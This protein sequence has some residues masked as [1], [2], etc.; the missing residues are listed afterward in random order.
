MSIFFI[1][2]IACMTRCDFSRSGSVSSSG[3][4]VRDDLPRQAEPVL[5]PA[6]RALLPA[7][8]ERVQYRV[9]LLLRLAVDDERDGLA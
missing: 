1:C 2:S 4:I 3:R 8:G 6:A 7:V 5:Q 9:D